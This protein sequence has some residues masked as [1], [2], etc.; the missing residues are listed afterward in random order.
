MAYQ[1]YFADL[2]DENQA[3][4]LTLLRLKEEAGRL[5]PEEAALLSTMRGPIAYT[6]PVSEVPDRDADGEATAQP[7]RRQG[8]F[9]RR[10]NGR[11]HHPSS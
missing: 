6:R 8:G 7:H 3:L 2:R 10:S 1:I 11:Q 9:R 4:L 5:E